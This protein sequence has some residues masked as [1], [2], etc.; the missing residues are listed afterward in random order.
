MSQ[1]HDEAMPLFVEKLFVVGPNPEAPGA[2]GQ[3]SGLLALFVE[4]SNVLLG[5]PCERA[6]GPDGS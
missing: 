2:R 6:P 1:W 4:P 5:T 3:G